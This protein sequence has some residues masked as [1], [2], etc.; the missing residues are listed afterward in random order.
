MYTGILTLPN[1]LTK[2]RILFAGYLEISTYTAMIPIIKCSC[3]ASFLICEEI[4]K[5]GQGKIFSVL[6]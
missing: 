5:Q 3:I 4:H 2:S 6:Q 1:S